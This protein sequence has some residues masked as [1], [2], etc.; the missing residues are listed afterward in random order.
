MAALTN[1]ADGFEAEIR[2]GQAKA[3]QNA[4]VWATYYEQRQGEGV[5]AATVITAPAA[6][7]GCNGWDQQ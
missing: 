1:S 7:S 6:V 3:E 2:A 5:P 4:G